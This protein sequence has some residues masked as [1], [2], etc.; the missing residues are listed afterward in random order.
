MLALARYRLGL[1]PVNNPS[2][3]TSVT[4]GPVL[5]VGEAYHSTVIVSD[6]VPTRHPALRHGARPLAGWAG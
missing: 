5:A 4:S 2:L 1:V 6:A 3:A